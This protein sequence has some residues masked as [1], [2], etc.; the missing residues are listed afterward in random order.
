MRIESSLLQFYVYL[1]R[2][3]FHA[4]LDAD[5][6]VMTLFR[7]PISQKEITA[8]RLEL[9]SSASSDVLWVNRRDFAD[10]C[11]SLEEAIKAKPDAPGYLPLVR[12][13]LAYLLT[14]PELSQQS[15]SKVLSAKLKSLFSSFVRETSADS[16]NVSQYERLVI[17]L[18]GSLDN[19]LS[20]KEVETVL[21][22]AVIPQNQWSSVERIISL[23]GANKPG[24]KLIADVFAWANLWGQ[25][26]IV[27]NIIALTGDNQLSQ[28]DVDHWLG[29]FSRDGKWGPVV[30]L[31]DLTGDNKPSQEVEKVLRVAYENKQWA[32]VEKIIDLRG[33]T[34]SS[35]SVEEAFKEA[36]GSEQLGSIE[37]LLSL[38]GDNKLSMKAWVYIF[39]ISLELKKWSVV[40]KML[41]SRVDR[42]E[43]STIVEQALQN[44]GID[45]IETLLGLTGDNKLSQEAVNYA[46]LVAVDSGQ[47]VIVEKILGM[48]GDNKPSLKVVCDAL[49]HAAIHGMVAVVEKILGMTG[50]NKP[51]PSSVEDSLRR[52]LG[53]LEY[54]PAPP[55]EQV[56]K[57]MAVVDKILN[58]LGNDA[59]N[60]NLIDEAVGVW[61]KYAPS[62]VFANDLDKN[63]NNKLHLATQETDPLKAFNDALRDVLTITLHKLCTQVNRAGW[64]PI[65]LLYRQCMPAGDQVSDKE[66]KESNLS[67]LLYQLAL[68]KFTSKKDIK[69]VLLSFAMQD[70]QPEAWMALAMLAHSEGQRDLQDQCIVRLTRYSES[71]KGKGFPTLWGRRIPSE[72]ALCQALLSGDASSI[73]KAYDPR[74]VT[75]FIKKYGKEIQEISAL[76]EGPAATPRGPQGL[77]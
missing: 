10:F 64:T 20:Q 69:R 35:T 4:D 21:W 42:R 68:L 40:E 76:S 65:H 23:T 37:K 18:I 1:Y 27:Q 62:L 43:R 9:E 59:L 17:E 51:G 77:K 19:Q 53:R 41:A 33:D 32:V 56:L 45:A 28:E 38:K 11:V 63:G 3:N 71:I 70:K 49:R 15:T 36:V 5:F 6:D 26:G 12:I 60:K 74:H 14:L 8:A 30:K 13:G 2:K 66:L 16:G 47:V 72:K 7:N 67:G 39:M 54:F 73:E 29:S 50:D 52:V 55:Q 57:Q 44:W 48:T 61:E 58:A 75:G 22:E 34:L 31:L 25:M 24:K 46:L